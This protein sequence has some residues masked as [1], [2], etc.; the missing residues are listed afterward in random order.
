[1]ATRDVKVAHISNSVRISYMTN[2]SNNDIILT[3]IE[4]CGAQQ[5]FTLNSETYL[6]RNENLYYIVFGNHTNLFDIMITP[7]DPNWFDPSF[8]RG[9]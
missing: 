8:L 9:R 7:V 4:F 6:K 3:S 5:F 2:K 1:M